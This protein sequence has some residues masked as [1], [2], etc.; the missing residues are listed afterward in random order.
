[1]KFVLLIFI[2]SICMFLLMYCL[3]IF[4]PHIDYY[5]ITTDL[6]PVPVST[7]DFVVDSESKQIRL[8]ESKLTPLGR[9]KTGK[10]IIIDY[11]NEYEIVEV[12][13]SPYQRWKGEKK[14]EG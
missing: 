3:Y 9:D 11:E 7:V 14:N 12:L 13:S 1:M 6:H 4:L 5:I 8:Y 2:F 10:V